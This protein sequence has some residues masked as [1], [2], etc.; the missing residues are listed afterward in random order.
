MERVVNLIVGNAAE[1]VKSES[2]L[3]E[4]VQKTLGS[5]SECACA[6]GTFVSVLLSEC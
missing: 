3:A 2:Y 1:N 6:V 4:I 5:Q